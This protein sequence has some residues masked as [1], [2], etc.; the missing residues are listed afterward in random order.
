MSTTNLHLICGGPPPP[1]SG[2]LWA[3]PA[4]R[5]PMQSGSPHGP[6]PAAYLCAG[7]VPLGSDDLRARPFGIR[8]LETNTVV[9]DLVH[10]PGRRHLVL[11]MVRDDRRIRWWLNHA[12]IRPHAKATLVDGCYRYPLT[13]TADKQHIAVADTPVEPVPAAS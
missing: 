4:D 5:P 12:A 1:R 7:V 3:C 10:N 8:T 2:I 6:L 9:L 13:V 11:D